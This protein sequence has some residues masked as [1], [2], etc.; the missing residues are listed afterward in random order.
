MKN[1]HKALAWLV[2]TTLS[3]EITGKLR[4]DPSVE[5]TIVLPLVSSPRTTEFRWNLETMD[6]YACISNVD[7]TY[8]QRESIEIQLNILILESEFKRWNLNSGII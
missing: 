4:E 1:K 2:S 8:S 5:G 3:G 6:G 7:A